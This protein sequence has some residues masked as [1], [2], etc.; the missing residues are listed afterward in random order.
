VGWGGEG[1]QTKGRTASAR[2]G[3][4]LSDAK[5]RGHTDRPPSISSPSVT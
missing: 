2:G 1:G 4:E 5:I 3:W